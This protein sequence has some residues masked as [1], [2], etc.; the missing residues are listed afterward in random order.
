MNKEE[1]TMREL[2]TENNKKK[3]HLFL[4]YIVPLSFTSRS[5]Q[6]LLFGLVLFLLHEQK[7]ENEHHPLHSAGGGIWAYH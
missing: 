1:K 4:G 6:L 5:I 3:I 7:E 2:F